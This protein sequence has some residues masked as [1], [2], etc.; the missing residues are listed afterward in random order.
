MGET[1][2]EDELDQAAAG[3]RAA[4]DPGPGRSRGGK[5]P[6]Q[7]RL[8]ATAQYLSKTFGPGE[9]TIGGARTTALLAGLISAVVMIVRLLVPEPAGMADQGDGHR[10]LCA[11]GVRN[12]RPW[13]YT[14]FTR[15]LRPSWVPHQ[16]YGE[17]CGAIGSGEPY[18]SSQLLLLWPGKFLTPLLG[19]GPGLDTRAV[20]IV[21]C[22]VFGL[23]IAG[24][25]AVL[26]G[27]RSFRVLIAAVVTMVM[28]DGVF[29]GFFVSPYSE[30]GAFLGTLAI[31]V[32]LL[33]YWNGRG[34]RWL[35]VL[36]VVL[37]TVFTVSAKTQTVSWVPVVAFALLWL[38]FGRR[39][40]AAG[41]AA[42]GPG[43]QAA[44]VRLRRGPSHP[45]RWPTS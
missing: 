31:C 33:H 22:L 23:L 15:F 36:L 6:Q 20:G 45:L 32:T 1:R 4:E 39:T 9:L 35:A 3:R 40:A 43:R 11:L 18:Y 26:P 42:V 34:P 5:G 19:W 29:A 13:D 2:Q 41:G 21:C 14:E 27:R 17:G 37:A 44:N 8:R 16:F 7:G 28:A 24:L 10:L 12:V 30:A 25:I 38:P